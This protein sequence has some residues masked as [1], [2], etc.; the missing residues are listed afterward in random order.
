MTENQWK[1]F[2]EV[3][4]V[5]LHNFD[6]FSDFLYIFTVPMFSAPI[7]VLMV[8]SI[9]LPVVLIGAFSFTIGEPFKKRAIKFFLAFTGTSY[10]HKLAGGEDSISIES[11]DENKA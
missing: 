2:Q 8:V 5:V 10:L 11:A 1:I 3:P 4:T 9:A 6:V 7:K